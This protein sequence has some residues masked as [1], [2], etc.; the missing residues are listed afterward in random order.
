MVIFGA[1][2]SPY[3][4][5]QVLET[6]LTQPN[7]SIKGLENNFYVDNFCKTY[8]S[9]EEA[10]REKPAIENILMDA[11]M[12]LQGWISNSEEFNK[13]FNVNVIASQNMLGMEWNVINDTLQV[14]KS[15]KFPV[16][17]SK[18]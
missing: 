7:V 13:Q 2:S 3:I 14:N 12:P 9:V 6:H 1:C 11:N 8:P 18:W 10:V 5:Q 15:K 17:I 16:E 4:L